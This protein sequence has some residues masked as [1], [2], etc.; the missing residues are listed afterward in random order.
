[1]TLRELLEQ[2]QTLDTDQLDVELV[3][4]VDDMIV[5]LKLIIND[6]PYFVEEFGN[7][8]VQNDELWDD[9]YMGTLLGDDHVT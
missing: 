3:A 6:S 9:I 7:V 2:L 1:M 8:T 5:P 4:D